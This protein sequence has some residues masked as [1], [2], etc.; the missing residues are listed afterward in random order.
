MSKFRRGRPSVERRKSVYYSSHAPALDLMAPDTYNRMFDED[1]ALG[2]FPVSGRSARPDFRVRLETPDAAREAELAVS[3]DGSGE[4][5]LA[6]GLGTFLRKTVANVLNDGRC[7][8]EVV[9]LAEDET[10]PPTS[11]QLAYV[12]A[13]QLTERHGSLMQ[14][15]PPEVAAERGVATEITLSREDMLILSLPEDLAAT[16]RTVKA[17]LHKIGRARYLEFMTEA[18]TQG[19]PYDFARHEKVKMLALAEAGRLLGWTARGSFNGEV[20]SYYWIRMQLDFEAFKLRMRE[21]LLGQLNQTLRHAGERVGFAATIQV[22]G[23]PTLT[24]IATARDRLHSGNMAFT[25]VMKPFH[26]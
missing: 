11:F 17:S 16:V 3:L 14:L 24:D 4:R 6:G 19:L 23:L 22:E 9:Y 18:Q 2:I 21:H 10:A 15:V 25:E 13:R 5:S 26:G 8:Y 12:S 1:V 7:A 20:L